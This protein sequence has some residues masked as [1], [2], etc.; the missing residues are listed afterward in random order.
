MVVRESTV[1]LYQYVHIPRYVYV[2]GQDVKKRFMQCVQYTSLPK[3]VFYTII[4]G[5]Y[6]MFT[7]VMLG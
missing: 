4:E 1:L 3:T 5:G 2:F 6:L 7:F